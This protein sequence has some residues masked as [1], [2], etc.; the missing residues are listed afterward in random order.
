MTQDYFIYAPRLWYISATSV[1]HQCNIN[2]T[3]VQHQCNTS[4]TCRSLIWD[5][6][7]KRL[8]NCS[9]FSKLFLSYRILF[10]AL[11][12]QLEWES[13]IKGRHVALVLHWCCNDVALMLRWCCTDLVLAIPVCKRCWRCW[14][15]NVIAKPPDDVLTGV[16]AA[17]RWG[18]HRGNEQSA[19]R[20]HGPKNN[21]RK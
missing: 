19:G 1:Q 4:T 10:R 12:E 13:H 5:S 6:H 17:P 15:C 9:L 16:F 21:F 2:A 3:S 7:F 20:K 18:G 11:F 14:R 8:I